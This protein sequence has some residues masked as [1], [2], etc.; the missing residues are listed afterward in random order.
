M[1]IALGQFAVSK[2]RKENLQTVLGLMKQA[3]KEKAKLLVLQ[4]G[5]SARDIADR[6]IALK[7]VQFPDCSFVT[8]ILNKS[9]TCF[10][11]LVMTTH[12]K[13]GNA[14]VYN[15]QFFIKDGKIIAS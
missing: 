6:Y 5:I 4:E 3:E 7:L 1:K 14:R 8:E 12:I 15:N 2:V 9:Q 13:M 11:A 10:S